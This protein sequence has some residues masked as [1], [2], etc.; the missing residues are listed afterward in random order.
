MSAEALRRI[1]WVAAIR[2]PQQ[3]HGW[4]LADWDLV[5]RVGRRLRLLA[6]LAESLERAE[7]LDLVPEPVRHHLVAE[8]RVS[9][10]R[11]AAMTWA[12]ARVRAA[13]AEPA[14]PCVLLKGAAYLGQGL[15]IAPG[16]MPSDVDILVPRDH[17]DEARRRLQADGWTEVALDAHDQRYYR[18]WSH[19]VPPMRHALH[20]IELDLHHGIR[21]PVGV[22][23]VDTDAL[24]AC[25]Q[26]SLWP[27]WQVLQPVDQL[28][29]SAV[30]LITDSD[31]RDRLRDLVDLDGLLRHFGRDAAFADA[32]LERA[33]GLGLR[34]PLAIAVRFCVEW[35]GTPL[36]ES[37]RRVLARWEP[38]GLRR[39]WLLPALDALLAPTD[40]DRAAPWTQSLAAGVFLVHHQAGRL[41]LRLLVPHVWHKL[42][43]AG[44]EAT[45]P[46]DGL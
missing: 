3:V 14:H 8:Q 26:P 33:A 25:L 35:L 9:R 18:D 45:A 12:L 15:P 4:T 23:P 24:L 5:V 42:R 46:R 36:P 40:P 32:L 29:H 20:P 43:A 37:A 16:R 27:G 13:L 19:E 34:E 6:R 17:L 1:A 2:E 28:L 38:R 31:L 44:R 39:A 41:P 21:P 30:H 7:L 11:T 22:F 10:Y